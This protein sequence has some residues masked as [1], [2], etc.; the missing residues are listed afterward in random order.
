MI[1]IVILSRLNNLEVK[2]QV[3]GSATLVDVLVPRQGTLKVGSLNLSKALVYDIALIVSFALLT[4]ICAQIAI[5]I[6][7]TT[8]P[9]TGQTFAVLLT[10]AALGSRRG[11]LSMAV[12]M[13][14]GMFFLPIFAPPGSVLAKETMHLVFPWSGTQGLVWDLSSGGYI[15]G[16][17]F[18]SY[19]TGLLA[20]R[21]WDRR[22][23]VSLAMIIGNSI[24]YL[25]GLAWLSI[26]IG[27]G[28]VIPG[29]EL[30]Y[31]D[32]ISGNNVLDKT[33]KGG[34][35]PFLGGDAIKL[36]LASLVLPGAWA[37]VKLK[38]K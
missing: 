14:I 33:L 3:P 22:A 17:V 16:F 15:V 28:Y 29:T 8:V 31:Y 6:P 25:F 27:T 37:L 32:A 5:K 4:A 34:L 26:Y 30:T 19:V 9:I 13:L 2:L 20:E 21:S 24:I 38:N 36:L 10:G 18:A 23:R 12:Y 11:A 7:T 1:E 35:Y